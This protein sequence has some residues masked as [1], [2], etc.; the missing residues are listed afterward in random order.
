M[1]LRTGAFVN[2]LCKQSLCRPLALTPH[3]ILLD[4]SVQDAHLSPPAPPIRKSTAPLT[5]HK[6]TQPRQNSPLRIAL[7]LKF[8]SFPFSARGSFPAEFPCNGAHTSDCGRDLRN[9][10]DGIA[11]WLVF[12]NPIKINRLS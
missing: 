6:K 11:E 10:R 8:D 3:F 7:C 2:R 4:A 12:Y 9:E 1:H 5:P